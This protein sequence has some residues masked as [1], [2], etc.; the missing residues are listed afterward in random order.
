MSNNNHYNRF[1]ILIPDEEIDELPFMASLGPVLTIL[2]VYLVFVLKIGPVFMRKREGYKLT[3][4]LL[5]YNAIQVAF[6]VYLV[7]RVSF[8]LKYFDYNIGWFSKFLLTRKY[9]CYRFPTN[10]TLHMYSSCA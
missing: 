1:N 10:D 9:A 3:Y 8:V 7:Y 2:A 4:T 5:I 6:S